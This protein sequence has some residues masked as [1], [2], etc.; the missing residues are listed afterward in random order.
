M[1]HYHLAQINIARAKAPLDSPVMHGFT[2]RLEAVNA[3]AEGSPGFIWRLQTEEG[4]ATSLRVF[5]DP[6][7]IVNLSVWRDVEALK[8]FVFSGEHLQLLQNKKAW[9]DK[10]TTPSLALWWVPAG[11]Q[12]SIEEA[13]QALHD[14][15]EHG[16]SPRAF[17]IAQPMP[18]PL[19]NPA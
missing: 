11:H 15:A 16:S 1:P 10:L 6:Q 3:I 7:I 18:Q 2:S 13:K 5:A 9:F 8:A 4:D 17:S 19:F 12:P 14:L